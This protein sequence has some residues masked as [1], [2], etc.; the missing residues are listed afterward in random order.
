M[1]ENI[2]SV[3]YHSDK[4]N[5]YNHA[6]P[7]S[8]KNHSCIALYCLGLLCCTTFAIFRTLIILL[9]IRRVSDVGVN[10]IVNWIVKGQ[11]IPSYGFFEQISNLSEYPTRDTNKS[12]CSR[13]RRDKT[14]FTLPTSCWILNSYNH[15]YNEGH[16]SDFPPE[17][18]IIDIKYI[19]LHN[20]ISSIETLHL[21]VRYI[22][23]VPVVWT[24]QSI[25]HWKLIVMLNWHF[26]QTFDFCFVLLKLT[27]SLTAP[28]LTLLSHHFSRLA[29]LKLMQQDYG[30]VPSV[31]IMFCKI[32]NSRAN[33]GREPRKI[34]QRV[35]IFVL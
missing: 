4:K 22:V 17:L 34:Q 31:N 26:Q 13:F 15:H 32:T 12:L 27:S 18:A 28:K 33:T 2:Y 23:L 14:N 8:S 16:W 21:M 5:Y 6:V 1:F 29:P 11:L 7:W 20:L 9:N 3:L 35:K 10:S 25:Q 19:T 30:S 24:I